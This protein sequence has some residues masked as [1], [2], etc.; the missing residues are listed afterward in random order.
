[1]GERMNN[2]AA[3][4]EVLRPEYLTDLP[5]SAES[6]VPGV[7]WGAVIGGAFV[8]ASFSLLLTI[9]GVGLGL[10]SV[11]P[12][13]GI[14]ATTTAIGA[15]AVVWLVLTQAI[16]TG[17]GGYLAGR[18][19]IKWINVHSDEI[20]FQDTAHGLL[21]WAVS[22]VIAVAFLASAAS[23]IIGS[24]GKPGPASTLATAPFTAGSPPVGPSV[25]T[26]MSASVP[27]GQIA[28]TASSDYLADAL[29]RN[30]RAGPDAGQSLRPEVGR[31]LAEALRR[32]A[33][34]N[35][36]RTYVGQV[37]AARTGMSQT[38]AELRVDAVYAQAKSIA[39]DSELAVRILA[40]QARQTAAK[41]SLWIF[42]ALLTG[43][44]C[45]SLAA[46][47]GGKQRDLAETTTG[48]H[49]ATRS[50]LSRSDRKRRSSCARCFSGFLACR[51]RS[52]S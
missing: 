29:F 16:A 4:G 21:V 48:L 18:L 6:S 49:R 44:F 9:L 42:V 52:S 35:A 47:L 43:A 27:T 32:G 33:M 39:A 41:A 37:I 45:A 8:A 50:R 23:S 12:W 38:D 28:Q 2:L 3:A 20:Y 25:A 22:V 14:G 36:D 19:R 17:L 7:S 51:F 15:S 24:T 40:D 46:T 5:P 30:D 10:S 31:V 26:G 1:M 34:P 13:A 11:S